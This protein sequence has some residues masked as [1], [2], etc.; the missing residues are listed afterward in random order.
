MKQLLFLLLIPFVLFSCE[1]KPPAAEQ[2]SGFV[3]SSVNPEDL[4]N[5]P[6]PTE[7]I[8]ENNDDSLKGIVNIEGLR[9]REETNQYSAT[10]RRLKLREQITILQIQ[11][12]PDA[13]GNMLA[14]WYFVKTHKGEKGWVYG[15][16]V[17]TEFFTKM[18]ENLVPVHEAAGLSM[19]GEYTVISPEAKLY[20]NLNNFSVA[21]YSTV[22][23]IYTVKGFTSYLLQKG[24]NVTRMARVSN[25]DSEGWI[26]ATHISPVFANKNGILIYCMEQYD[27]K[28]MP[29]YT[30]ELNHP[31][32]GKKQYTLAEL[33]NKI[34]GTIFYPKKIQFSTFINEDKSSVDSIE[35]S[36]FDVSFTEDYGAIALPL[37]YTFK[38]EDLSLL[39]QTLERARE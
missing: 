36:G 38:L 7:D 21:G 23:D 19:D 9:L 11:D 14:P 32:N 6:A 16:Y 5:S 2:T 33:E 28:G 30:L 1:Y 17:D 15:Y 24:R 12:K 29:Y 35:V 4:I 31:R 10:I 8:S 39:S 25:D 22:E 34:A 37:T 18:N 27:A 3:A 13:I 26:A 20:N